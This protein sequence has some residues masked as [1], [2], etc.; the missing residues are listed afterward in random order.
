MDEW[1]I[2]KRAEVLA[3]CGISNTTLKRR[4]RSG[5]FPAPV[6]LGGPGSRRVGWR[7]S[8]VRDWVAGLSPVERRAS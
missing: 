1:R 3:V 2:L 6:R 8:D 7:A 4:L 5:E